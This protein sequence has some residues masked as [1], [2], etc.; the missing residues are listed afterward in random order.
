MRLALAASATAPAIAGRSMPSMHL[1]IEARHGHQRAGIAG[2]DRDVGL[3]LLD[4]VDGQPH[5]RLPAP[6]AQRLAR[7]VVHA[8][9]RHRCGPTATRAFSRGSLSS[10]GSTTARSP[11]SRNSMSGWR[12]SEISAPGNTTEAPWSPPMASSAMRTLSGMESTSAAS[13][14]RSPADT[15]SADGSATAA[16]I[17][18]AAGAR[19][20]GCW[21]RSTACCRLTS[22]A[23]GRFF[24]AA[25]AAKGCVAA[26]FAFGGANSAPGFA[27]IGI[28]AEDQEFGGQRAEIDLAVD[29]RLPAAR[30]IASSAL[31]S[32]QPARGSARRREERRRSPPRPRSRSARGVT[33][34][35]WPTRALTWPLTAHARA[36]GRVRSNAAV[37]CGSVAHAGELGD[38]GAR[39]GRRF[40]LDMQAG[41]RDIVHGHRHA[42]RMAGLSMA[43]SSY[44]A[45]LA[46]WITDSGGT[47]KRQFAGGQA[48]GVLPARCRT[49]SRI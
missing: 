38:R 10:S 41:L 9:R 47:G 37:S 44:P 21:L 13:D 45:A 42:P 33:T 6:V 49:A 11:N 15:V 24:S 7:L 25:S 1:E 35:V 23:A 16:T 3:A 31:A 18:V 32:A 40:D 14:R 30:R 36:A 26:V 22:A 8:D 12:V 48:A 34:Q 19:Q 20:A 27:R 43:S 46:C 4:R 28:D 39:R 2:R 29:Q 17:A 5:R